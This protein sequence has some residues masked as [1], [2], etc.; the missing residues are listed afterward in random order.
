MIAAEGGL[1][2]MLHDEIPVDQEMLDW[3]L[4]RE[5]ELTPEA[6]RLVTHLS[7]PLSGL[8]VAWLA[9]AGLREEAG[10][11]IGFC[12]AGQI[13]RSALPAGPAD[14]NAL[15]L[16]GGQRGHLTVRTELTGREVEAY[17]QSL[18][19]SDQGQTVWSGFRVELGPA[20]QLRS[21]LAPD[22]RYRVIMPELEWRTRFLR[23]VDRAREDGV[24]SPLTAREF[25]VRESPVTFTDAL[26]AYMERLD[27][28]G[29]APHLRADALA[30]ASDQPG[31]PVWWS[32]R[33]RVLPV[34]AATRSTAAR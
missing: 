22:R 6:T 31:N 10:A 19:G 9:A 16:T 24:E 21:D 26:T 28:H 32:P 18:S 29:V 34:P 2:P 5:A 7:E 33:F 17:V 13:I 8:Q 1:V 25:A 11:D 23:R 15:Y 30:A 3:V 14:V 4:R 12:H 27:A 20:G